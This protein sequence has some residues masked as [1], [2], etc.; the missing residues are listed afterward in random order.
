MNIERWIGSVID[1]PSV[2]CFRVCGNILAVSHLQEWR[3]DR[4]GQKEGEQNG[5]RGEVSEVREFGPPIFMTD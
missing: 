1:L 4:E 5:G 3:R 2:P